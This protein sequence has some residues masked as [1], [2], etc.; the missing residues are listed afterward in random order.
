MNIPPWLNNNKGTAASMIQDAHAYAHDTSGRRSAVQHGWNSASFHALQLFCAFM[1]FNSFQFLWLYPMIFIVYQLL[2]YLLSKN[3]PM[4]QRKVSNALLLLVSYGLYAKAN[5]AFTLILLGVTAVTYLF[6]LLIE[7]DT[8]SRKKLLISC[9]VILALLPLLVFKHYNFI[10]ESGNSLLERL[11]FSTHLPGLNWAVPLG[12]SFF[13]FQ[14]LG[15]LLDVYYQ[16]IKAERNWWD[17]MLFVSF[18]PQILAGPISKAKDLLPQIKS[19]RKFDETMAA[20][21]LKW[22]VWGLFLKVVMADRLGLYVDKVFDNYMYQS[23]ISCLVAS[24]LYSFQIYGDFAG[25]SFMALGVGKLMGFNLINNFQRPYLSTS[26]TDFW[27]RWHISLSTWLKDYVYIPL[28]GSR[29]AKG[30]NYWNIFVTFLVS[31]IWHGANWTFIFW[32]IL[33]GVFLIIEKMFGW[34]KCNT[35]RMSIRLLRIFLTFVLVTIAWIFFRQPTIGDAFGII[36]RI[37]TEHGSMFD[38]SNE[39]VF[40][41]FSI[42][43]VFAVVFVD[44]F[45]EFHYQSFQRLLAAPKVVRWAV[46]YILLLLILWSGVFDSSQ[47]IYVSF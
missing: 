10:I 45:R 2:S 14:A 38:P 33:H 35:H 44:V 20:Q 47:F 39:D 1:V 11:H 41:L 17:Y 25:Y 30:R 37:C 5:M 28:G 40:F 23:G 26:I 9:G 21:G 13:T 19:D 46:Y 27:R 24:V 8:V 43:S 16:R 4:R 31:G 22:F 15:Y 3:K 7:R 36:E 29:C 18:F 34:Q 6:A 42:L 32:G 12:I